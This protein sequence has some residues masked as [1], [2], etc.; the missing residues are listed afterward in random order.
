[1]GRQMRELFS[2]EFLNSAFRKLKG[3]WESFTVYKHGLK[4][5]PS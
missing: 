3:D 4:M 1:M 5:M 2:D